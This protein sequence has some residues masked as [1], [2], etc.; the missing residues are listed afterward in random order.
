MAGSAG[1]VRTGNF[2]TCHAATKQEPHTGLTTCNP[3]PHTTL[4]QAAPP[5][6]PGRAHSRQLAAWV[7]CYWEQ[8]CVCVVLCRPRLYRPC[9]SMEASAAGRQQQTVQRYSCPVSHHSGSSTRSV[10]CDPGNHKS[11]ATPMA[12]VVCKAPA[13]RPR[14]WYMQRPA[15]HQ[16]QQHTRMTAP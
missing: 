5:L 14:R 12:A 15:S 4:I 7:A 6:Q 16:R 13:W 10:P 9:S 2:R 11:A 1:P 8:V 3:C